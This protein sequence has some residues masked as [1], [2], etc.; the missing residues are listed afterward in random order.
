NPLGPVNLAASLQLSAN[1]PNFLAQE[2]AELGEGYLKKPF[3]V[4]DGYL[5]TPTAPGLGIEI[6]EEAIQDKLYTGDWDTPRWFHA[7]DGSVADW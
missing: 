2:H 5:E 6:D 7:D 1:V 4:K 3:V